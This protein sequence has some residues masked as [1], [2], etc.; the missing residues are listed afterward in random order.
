M[1]EQT[2]NDGLNSLRLAG[3]SCPSPQGTCA[4]TGSFPKIP[5]LVSSPSGL[6]SRSLL[7]FLLYAVMGVGSV[8]RK[9]RCLGK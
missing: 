7:T 9:D 4:Y 5:E 6:D 3:K 2:N 1:L 8:V